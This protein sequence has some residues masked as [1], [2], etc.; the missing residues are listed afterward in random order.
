MVYSIASL[1]GAV[2]LV[3]DGETLTGLYRQTRDWLATAA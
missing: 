2:A 1:I 3:L